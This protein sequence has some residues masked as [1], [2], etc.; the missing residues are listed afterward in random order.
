VAAWNSA[1][2]AGISWLVRTFHKGLF[3]AG[4]NSLMNPIHSALSTH[5][6]GSLAEAVM[7][8]ID[9]SKAVCQ[10]DDQATLSGTSW[11]DVRQLT[12]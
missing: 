8:A 11:E 3:A 2:A 5:E 9:L 7:G 1:T 6:S 10:T 12:D 4:K